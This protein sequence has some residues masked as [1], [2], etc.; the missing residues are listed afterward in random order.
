MNRKFVMSIALLTMASGLG[1]VL[2]IRYA[3]AQQ[4]PQQQPVSAQQ[5]IRYECYNRNGSLAFVTIDPY[6]T[7]GW[8]MGC[9]EV[10]YTVEADQPRVDYYQCYDGNGNIAFTTTNEE[11]V[12]QNDCR[13]IGYRDTTLTQN[14]PVYYECLNSKG[15]VAFTTRRHQDTLGWIPDCREVRT[16]NPITPPVAGQ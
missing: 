6:E 13:K 15:E 2:P 7:I 14:R 3:Q 1:T 4:Q 16:V 5:I 8:K 12:D 10:P 9:R 11:I